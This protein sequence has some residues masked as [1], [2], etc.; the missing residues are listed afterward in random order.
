MAMYQQL[1]NAVLIPFFLNQPFLAALSPP[2]WPTGMEW[3]IHGFGV[4]CDSE[5]KAWA[6]TWVS[7]LRMSKA[8]HPA[9]AQGSAL[10]WENS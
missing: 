3:Q 5:S 4:H 2:P 10:Q 8:P 9:V 1:T 6:S 7:P